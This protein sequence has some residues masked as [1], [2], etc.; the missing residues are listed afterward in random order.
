MSCCGGS[1]APS[2][3]SL[4]QATPLYAYL[5]DA[6]LNII[7]NAFVRQRVAKG[8]VLPE[9]P[10][11]I[12]LS[13]E[14]AVVL[15]SQTL[16]HKAGGSFFSRS[17]GQ[18]D[19]NSD[20]PAAALSF[21]KQQGSPD[22]SPKR[23]GRNSVMRGVMGRKQSSIG[24]GTQRRSI[25]PKRMSI[26]ANREKVRRTSQP[27]GVDD[28]PEPSEFVVVKPAVLLLILPEELEELRKTHP[29]IASVI[30]TMSHANLER[31]ERVHAPC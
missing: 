9:S 26:M 29:Q 23:G 10:F 15:D 14:V 6:E 16:C 5:D 25:A 21:M 19:E 4:L 28:T 13:G 27:I 2:I 22:S 1:A 30:Q 24:T 31:C 11:Y 12:L 18:V 3:V 20:S 8:L 17:A 7:A